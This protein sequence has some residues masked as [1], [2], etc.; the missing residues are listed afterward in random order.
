M[1][2]WETPIRGV[3]RFPRAPRKPWAMKSPTPVD[4]R[5]WILVPWTGFATLAE[6]E[7]SSS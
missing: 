2:S 5:P 3:D 6:E 7:T 4:C 1:A